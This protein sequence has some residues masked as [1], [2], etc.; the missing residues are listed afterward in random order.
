MISL[1]GISILMGDFD[2]PGLQS[3]MVRFS[4]PSHWHVCGRGGGLPISG[5]HGVHK[6]TGPALLP[7]DSGVCPHHSIDT[8]MAVPS[9]G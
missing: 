1:K 4:A 5:Y 2:L 8:G 6:N 9:V 3:L 7:G